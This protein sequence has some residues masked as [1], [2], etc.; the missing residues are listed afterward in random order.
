[1][2][3]DGAPTVW[4]EIG[5]SFP[6]L[7]DPAD[8]TRV[9]GP[10]PGSDWPGYSA[11]P[12]G[13]MITMYTCSMIPT[14]CLLTTYGDDNWTQGETNTT[15]LLVTPPDVGLFYVLVRSILQIGPSSDCNYAHAVPPNGITDLDVTGWPAKVFTV[16]VLPEYMVRIEPG[17]F[18]MGSPTTEPGRYVNE[19]QHGVTITR[20]FYISKNEVT[21]AQWSDVMN[22]NASQFV[23]P[24][25]PVERVTWFDCVLF[26]NY[27][28]ESESLEL[29]YTI[30]DRDETSVPPHI[31]A[32]TV[33]WD[34]SANGYR[35]PTE[36]E[37]EYACRAGSTT[38]FC[39]GPITATGEPCADD[40]ILSSV[41]WYCSNSGGTPREIGQLDPNAWGL[42]D[43]HGNV[44]EWCWDR[45]GDYP[46]YEVSDPAGPPS[47]FSRVYRG[48]SW[49]STAVSSRAALRYPNGPSYFSSYT[50]LRLARNA[51]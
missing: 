8:G 1:M 28:S 45:Y 51:E 16:R 49:A 18:Q 30:T 21:Q 5:I 23:N 35:L 15:N 19:T 10:P 38:A 48:G 37:W 24:L 47:G 36:A 43:V 33:T 26:C 27:L 20:P 7:R 25:N 12:D 11:Y 41:A 42:R 2:R 40:P 22:W 4:G 9:Q 14:Y 46:D 32:A 39:N 3:N 31:T 13:S 17:H 34:Q 44:L 50:G 29:A 6:D